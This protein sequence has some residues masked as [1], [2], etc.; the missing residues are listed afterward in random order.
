M[1]QHRRMLA[2]RIHSVP[3]REPDR[4][5][6][7]KAPFPSELPHFDFDLSCTIVWNGPVAWRESAR[8]AVAGHAAWRLSGYSPIHAS[9]AETRLAAELAAGCELGGALPIRVRAEDVSISVEPHLLDLAQQRAKRLREKQVLDAEH[10]V[11]RAEMRYL[12]NSI[13]ADL[14]SAARWWLRRHDHDVTQLE[15]V[16]PTLRNTVELISGDEAPETVD[17]IIAAFDTVAENLNQNGRY[18]LYRGLAEILSGLDK[19]EEADALMSR[20][21]GDPAVEEQ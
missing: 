21:R 5:T 20:I 19:H 6:P 2:G 11:E 1:W 13:F 8:Q 10:E 7:L 12:K 4:R 3:A 9:V 15:A 14:S 16:V 18:A 17:A